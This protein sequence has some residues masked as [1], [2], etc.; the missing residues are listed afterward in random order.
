MSLQ[1]IDKL[2]DYEL[3]TA[4][5]YPLPQLVKYYTDNG[6]KYEDVFK[7]YEFVFPYDKQWKNWYRAVK[8][9]ADRRNFTTKPIKR[10]ISNIW[11]Y[12]LGD[13]ERICYSEELIGTDT[14][15]GRDYSFKHI[16]GV[17]FYHRI[18][19]EYD[20]AKDDYV[21]KLKGVDKSYWIN[22]NP[23]MLTE[24][25]KYKP[26]NR[27]QKKFVVVMGRTYGGQYIFSEEEYQSGSIEKLTKTALTA[28]GLKKADVLEDVDQD[29]LNRALNLILKNP[30]ALDT[31][32][33]HINLSKKTQ[34]TSK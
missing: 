33:N 20:E 34:N 16:Q 18:T 19:H 15:T 24:L 4:Q 26:V 22:Y 3:P 29:D 1:E 28:K 32:A 6:F 25:Y 14:K 7:K 21:P 17:Y 23:D 11:R 13:N 10:Q 2:L 31:L 12:K 9:I 8:Q 30:R 27:E 5:L